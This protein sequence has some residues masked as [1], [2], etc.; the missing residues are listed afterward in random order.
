MLN[1]TI[2]QQVAAFLRDEAHDN[3]LITSHV[4]PDGDGIA[5]MLACGKVMQFLRKQYVLVVDGP[6][7]KRYTFLADFATIQNWSEVTLDFTPEIFLAVDCADLDRIGKVK[8]LLTARSPIINIDHHHGNEHFG[9]LNLVDPQASSATEL[10]Y[11]LCQ[12]LEVPVDTALATHI[13][14]GIVFDTGRFRYSQT[15]THT[16]QVCADL[17]AQAKLDVQTVAEKL[18]YENTLATMKLLG[19]ALNSLRLECAGRVAVITLDHS[20]LSRPEFQDADTEGFAD[21]AMSLQG[22]E[23]GVFIREPERHKIRISLRARN[24]VDVQ[25]IAEHFGG[26]G[27]KKAAGCRQEGALETVTAQLLQEIQKHLLTS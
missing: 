6:P 12:A 17:L 18:Y 2:V 20:T 3:F 10:L 19:I 23:V 7:P 22:I 15:S 27:H 16:F 1:Q 5:A 26:G 21:Y 24:H 13:Y 9:R 25:V 4:N 14:T 11:T 8:T